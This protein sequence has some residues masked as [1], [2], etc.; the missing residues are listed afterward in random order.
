MRYVNFGKPDPRFPSF[1]HLGVVEPSD[2]QEAGFIF[3][4]GSSSNHLYSNVNTM[5]SL[6]RSDIRASI[7]FVDFG[8]DAAALTYLLQEMEV[9][10]SLYE[11]HH[12]RGKLYYRKFDFSHFPAWFD[13]S[14]EMIRG[15][16][17]WK[18]VSYFDVLQETRGIVVWSDG[19][20]Q[21]PV[22]I[23]KELWRVRTF[24]LYTPYSGGS[25]QSW[26][27]GKSLQFL[28]NNKMFRKAM[29]GKG[30]CTGGYLFINYQNATVMNQVVFPLVQCAYTRRCISPN[31][32][33]RKNHRQD[34]SILTVLVHSAKI[35]QSCHGSY[36][37]RV[38]YHQE[39][40]SIALCEPRKRQL[41]AELYH[42]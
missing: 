29:L 36:N 42:K 38:R 16:Y 26:M 30:M 11:K 2:L 39:C 33:S 14:D 19:G 5:Y 31:G 24:G 25:L 23:E 32:S 4:T 8:L 6:M 15:G 28:V 10:H 27:H 7:V 18:V 3:V 1:L 40:D 22:S 41:L 37:T 21:L 9:M 17:S 20:N 35:Q 12:S 13:I 34:Q